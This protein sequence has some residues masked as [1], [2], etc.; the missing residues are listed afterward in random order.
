MSGEY[1][2]F[3]AP[4]HRGGLSNGQAAKEQRDELSSSEGGFTRIG[5]AA[6]RDWMLKVRAQNCAG[7]QRKLPNIR[8][9][10]SLA[11]IAAPPSQ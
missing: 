2:K 5:F 11:I 1:K 6:D 4:V 9:C 7:A 3:Q 8:Y 10:C